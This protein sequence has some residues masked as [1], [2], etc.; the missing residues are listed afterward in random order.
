MGQEPGSGLRCFWFRVSQ[1]VAAMMSAKVVV[2]SEALIGLAVLLPKVAPQFLP[3]WIPGGLLE[4]P[5]DMA[6]GFPQSK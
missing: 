4:C 1:E 5:R 3:V 6:T 2:S